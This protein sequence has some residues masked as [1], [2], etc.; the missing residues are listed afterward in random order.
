MGSSLAT[1][2]STWMA[3]YVPRRD[4]HNGLMKTQ[5]PHHDS[6]K[7]ELDFIKAMKLD[8]LPKPVAALGHPRLLCVVL[9]QVRLPHD[10]KKILKT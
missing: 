9:V 5:S 7:E 4:V 1:E 8:L 3:I 6:V 10:L 2:R